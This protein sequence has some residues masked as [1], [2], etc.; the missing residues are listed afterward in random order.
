MCVHAHAHFVVSD[1]VTAPLGSITFYIFIKRKKKKRKNEDAE[2]P[3]LGTGF[4]AP[5]LPLCGS[6]RYYMQTIFRKCTSE[7]A[8]LVHSQVQRRS[9]VTHSESPSVHPSACNQC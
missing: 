6:L 4:E 9:T 8:F 5:L 7:G 1:S 3:S 2:H